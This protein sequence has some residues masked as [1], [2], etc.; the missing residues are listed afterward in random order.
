DCLCFEV[1]DALLL[2][3]TYARPWSVDP[4]AW[5]RRRPKTIMTRASFTLARAAGAPEENAV[6]ALSAHA[7]AVSEEAESLRAAQFHLAA[8]SKRS[9]RTAKRRVVENIQGPANIFGPCSLI[10]TKEP[11]AIPAA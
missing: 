8:Q 1:F 6:A 7:L 5:H 4:V 9:K 10:T 11:P 2:A 3:G